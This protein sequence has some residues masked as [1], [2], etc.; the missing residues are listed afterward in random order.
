SAKCAQPHIARPIAANC[1]NGVSIDAIVVDFIMSIAPK[2]TGS[3]SKD[4]NSSVF[5][6]NPQIFFFIF[7]QCVNITA[8]DGVRIFGVVYV[9]SKCRFYRVKQIQTTTLCSDPE[10]VVFVFENG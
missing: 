3:F 1:I 2:F 7:I 4:T 5:G 10:A 9:M 8:G 6:T